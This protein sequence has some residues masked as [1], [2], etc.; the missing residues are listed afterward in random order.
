[1]TYLRGYSN[2]ETNQTPNKPQV[3]NDAETPKLTDEYRKLHARPW[4]RFFARFLD[5]SVFGFV[6]G[7]LSA[8]FYPDFF[9]DKDSVNGLIILFCWFLVEPIFLS[10]FG[11]TLGKY[12][13]NIKVRD[14][15]GNKPKFYSAFARS[16][17]VWCAG[18]G[19]GI[20]IVYLFTLSSSYSQL[21]NTGTTSWDKNIFVVTHGDYGLIKSIISF[22][23]I[24][25]AIGLQIWSVSDKYQIPNK[26]PSSYDYTKEIEKENKSLPV[27]LDSE[28]EFFKM[29]FS[30]NTLYYQYR[31]V[32]K[33]AKDINSSMYYTY[34]KNQIL[35]KACSTSD[36]NPT[37]AKGYNLS[38]EYFDKNNNPITTILIKPSDCKLSQ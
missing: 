8:I 15:N 5:L 12:L 19:F 29:S 14:L 35:P 25:S 18:Y 28:T 17:W 7:I 34:M 2:M 3:V 37:L 16:F 9:S 22:L 38:F 30:N 21:K 1:M 20:P 32:N 36:P 13:F 11:T 4:T 33:D 6:L 23:I 27:M 10:L 24:S 31:L 26:Q